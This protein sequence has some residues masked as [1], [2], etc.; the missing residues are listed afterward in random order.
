[1]RSF[2][3]STTRAILLASTLVIFHNNIVRSEVLEDHLK[4]AMSFTIRDDFNL[5]S[6]NGYGMALARNFS[7]RT[8][9]RISERIRLTGYDSKTYDFYTASSVVFIRYVRPEQRSRFYWGIGPQVS[10]SNNRQ[11][12][13]SYSY[14]Y[15]TIG[16]IGIFGIE[17]RVLDFLRFHTEY[18]AGFSYLQEYR[19]YGHYAER[20]KYTFQLGEGVLLGL[21]LYF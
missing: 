1:M 19:Y 3:R 10:Y 9:L 4:W 7:D 18:S 5:D 8:T 2:L 14:K 16:S 21:T 11:E 13:N 17:V 15:W 12:D 20:S 6:Y